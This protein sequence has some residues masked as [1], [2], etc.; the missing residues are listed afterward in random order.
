MAAP[1]GIWRWAFPLGRFDLATTALPDEIMRRAGRFGFKA[2]PTG[3]AHGTVTLIVDGR[4]FETTTLR[5]DVE[6]D[7]RHAKVVFGR[8][9][10]ADARRRDLTINALS[11]DR[12]GFVHDPVGRP[13][14]SGRAPGPLH[15]RS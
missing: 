6:T 14:R 8:D 1:C 10:D 12:D 3:L 11:L 4:P 9:F 2:I 5:E 7:G 13:F 15:R